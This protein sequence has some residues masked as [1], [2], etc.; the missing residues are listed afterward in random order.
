MAKAQKAMVAKPPP[1]SVGRFDQ[2]LGEKIRTRRLHADMSQE[3]LASKLGVSFQQIQKYEKGVNRISAARLVEIAKALGES[4]AF[5]QDDAPDVSRAGRKLQA[6]I[7]DPINLRV[8]KALRSI[9]NKELR[10]S[11]ARMIEAIAGQE[12]DG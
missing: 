4:I 10:Y 12:D 9:D 6:L 8:C 11:I 7:S 3:Q 2:D 1:R 5:F